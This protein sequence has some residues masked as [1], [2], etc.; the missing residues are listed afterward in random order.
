MSCNRERGGLAIR[1]ERIRSSA[2]YACSDSDLT[3][4]ISLNLPRSRG[5]RAGGLLCSRPMMCTDA[6]SSKVV[7]ER[8]SKIL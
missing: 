6:T 2:I 4:V 1:T 5:L 7:K 3:D 8:E